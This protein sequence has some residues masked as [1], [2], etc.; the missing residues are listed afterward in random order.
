[1]HLTEPPNVVYWLRTGMKVALSLI[2]PL[3]PPR[4]TVKCK[5][6]SQMRYNFP[7][8]RWCLGSVAV[9]VSFRTLLGFVRMIP[10][11]EL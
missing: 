4:L 3:V 5:L 1:M 2:W 11:A 9:R 10:E 8:V 7:V 6:L